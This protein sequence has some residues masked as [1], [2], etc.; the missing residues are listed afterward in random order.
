MVISVLLNTAV[1]FILQV[2][3]DPK[4]SHTHRLLKTKVK[5]EINDMRYHS[6]ITEEIREIVSE[7]I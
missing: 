7:G 3:R 5:L 2:D 1:H 4:R 6:E